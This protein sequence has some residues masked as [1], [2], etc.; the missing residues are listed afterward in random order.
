MS[1]AA[2]R[3]AL[4]Y[5]GGSARQAPAI[6]A[7]R[8][9]GLFVALTDRSADAPARDHADSFHV[10]D[11]A[12]VDGILT[13]ADGLSAEHDLVGAYGI[14]DYTADAIAALCERFDLALNSADV[15]RIA[16]DKARA[17]TCLED[18]GVPVARACVQAPGEDGAAFAGRS[19][20]ELSFPLVVKPAAGINSRG[21]VTIGKPDALLLEAAILR[22]GTDGP[23]IV[24]EGAEGRHIN[25]D[26]VFAD[27]TAHPLALTERYFRPGSGHVPLYGVQ[28][29]DLAA[30][31]REALHAT[32]AAAAR[33][34]G[35]GEGPVTVD[36]ILTASG[37]IVLEVSLHYHALSVTALRDQGRSLG[38]WFARL[39]GDGDWQRYLSGAPDGVGAYYY[40]YGDAAPADR[41]AAVLESV[42]DDPRYCAV[43]RSSGAG[44]D[45]S[46]PVS[47]V[48]SLWSV[49]GGDIDDAIGTLGV[50]LAGGAS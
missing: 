45:G 32:A 15:Y 48:L 49:H 41:I 35:V 7:A 3:P 14:A 22:A 5:I 34:I 16:A 19:A 33:A 27:G 8:A 23:V 50:R 46:P 4:L 18:V 40:L 24:E 2:R 20:A 25:V 21:V 31:D 36:L 11:A 6:A 37:P 28:P 13:L 12:D 42:S 44:D 39:A 10:I 47:A 26:L 17:R 29:P 38:A 30:P 43:E 9:A 1:D